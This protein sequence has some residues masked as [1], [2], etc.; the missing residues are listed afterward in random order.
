MPFSV[1]LSEKV[2]SLKP[3]STLAVTARA[4]ELKKAGVDVVSMAAGEPDF[5]TPQHIKDAAIV[6]LKAGKTKY[7][8]VQGIIELRETISAKLE[9]ENGLKYSPDHITVSTGGKQSLFNAFMAFLDPGDEV[10]IPAPFWVSYPEMIAFAGGVPV[11]VDT[12]PE[13]GYALDPED[14]SRAVTPRTKAIMLNSPANPTGVVYDEATIRRVVEIALEHGLL[15]VT[16]EMYEHIIYGDKHISAAGFDMDHVLTIN[17]ASKAYSMTGWRIGY[18][19]GPAALIKA[20][21]AIQGQS[22]SNPNT[23]AQWAAVAAIADSREYIAMARAKFQ[24][25]RDRIVAGLNA[26]G[27]KTP[28]PGG[29]F[30]VMADTTPIHKDEMEA[31]RVILDQAQV[32]VVP[33]TDFRAPGRVRLSYATSMEQIEEA[34]SRIGKLL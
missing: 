27:L 19:A 23:L 11:F 13:N 10:I 33:G 14:I 20:M 15:V 3:S 1:A 8:A 16:D 34:L 5:D 17:G 31:A 9:R 21:N 30:Y 6:A 29:A 22:T 2:R 26:L 12:L 25:R 7:T 32:A 24:E 4:Q 28:L 18:A